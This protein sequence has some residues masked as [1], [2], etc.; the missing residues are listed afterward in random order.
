MMKKKVGLSKRQ[1]L[2]L[3]GGIALHTLTYCGGGALAIS[4]TLYNIAVSLDTQIPFMPWTVL[5][6]WGGI[7]FWVINY[8][9]GV[10][11]DKGNGNRFIAAH[12]IGMIISFF[13]FVFFPV[14][15]VRPEITGNS[16]FEWIL[17]FTYQVDQGSNCFPSMHCFFSWLCWI[18]VRRNKSIPGAYRVISLLIAVAICISTLTVK[19]HYVLDVPAGVILAE[20]SYLLAS[21]FDRI[22]S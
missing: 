4:K 11:Y 19:Q 17:K 5:I 14:K 6:Y 12:Y 18:G 3:F 9:A 7:L 10:K 15:M 8:I 2:L 20:I 13:F 1:I 21:K 22:R 16:V